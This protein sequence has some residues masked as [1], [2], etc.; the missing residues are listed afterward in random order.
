MIPA[1]TV[2]CSLAV[3]EY[4]RYSVQASPLI[5]A[6]GADRNLGVRLTPSNVEDLC[7]IS[8]GRP[9]IRL[10]VSILDSFVIFLD[11][12]D[13]STERMMPNARK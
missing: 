1:H 3:F 11:A 4:V 13:A 6:N 9:T 2:P 5:Q 12:E 7:V 10:L 8:Y